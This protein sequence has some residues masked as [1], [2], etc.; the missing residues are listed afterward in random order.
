MAV[1]WLREK[2]YQSEREQKKIKD[3]L[4]VIRYE[5]V[6][7]FG[8]RMKR[9]QV[10]LT[11]SHAQEAQCAPRHHSMMNLMITIL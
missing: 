9:I 1:T 8:M 2:T 7:R 3:K 10:I 6:F 11:I 5:N 4:D